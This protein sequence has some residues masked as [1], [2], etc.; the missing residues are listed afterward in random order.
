MKSLYYYISGCLI[1]AAGGG[2]VML[3]I[4]LADVSMSEPV[5][6]VAPISVKCFG[7]IHSVI[8]FS[9]VCT[10]LAA[11][12]SILRNIIRKRKYRH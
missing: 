12:I 7:I 11:V 2:L 6:S 4:S 9:F 1:I 10:F 3:L 8:G 5:L